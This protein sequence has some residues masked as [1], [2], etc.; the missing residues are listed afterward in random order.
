MT[1]IIFTDGAVP[2]NQKSGPK[3]GGIGVFFGDNDSRNLSLNINKQVTK[4]TNMV[5]EIYACIMALETLLQTTKIGKNKIT[6]YTDSMYIVNTY[7]EWVEKWKANNWKKS[8]NTIIENKELV[9]KLYYLS[10]NMK[11]EYIH[12][13]AHTKQPSKDSDEYFLWYGN[14]MADKLAVNGVKN[15]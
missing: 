3:N 1:I 9:I 8:N 2:N 13:K 5:C 6:I 14:M 4:V 11:V 12:V 7:Y 15:N 10:I